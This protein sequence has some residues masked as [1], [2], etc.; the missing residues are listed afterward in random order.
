M[1]AAPKTHWLLAEQLVRQEIAPQV[2]GLQGVVEILGQ[3]PVPS[4]EAGLV[5]TPPLQLA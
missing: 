4:Q 1:H 2:N 3:V 5:W